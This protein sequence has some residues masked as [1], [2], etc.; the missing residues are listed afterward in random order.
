MVL[1]YGSIETLVDQGVYANSESVI[2]ATLFLNR[3]K[4]RSYDQ[5]RDAQWLLRTT[6]DHRGGFDKS[7]YN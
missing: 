3:D 6:F 7:S 4:L 1:P 5:A 2:W